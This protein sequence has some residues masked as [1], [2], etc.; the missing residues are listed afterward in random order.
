MTRDTPLRFRPL[1][2]GPVAVFDVLAT[3]ERATIYYASFRDETGATRAV[4]AKRLRS[5]IAD[6]AKLAN[7]FAAH[8]RRAARFRH[9]NV[10][11]TIAV[12][13]EPGDVCSVKEYVPGEGL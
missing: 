8:A 11:T 1:V 9:P 5:Q 7:V 6:Q 3:S 12:A 13:Q 10:V 2:I 4:V